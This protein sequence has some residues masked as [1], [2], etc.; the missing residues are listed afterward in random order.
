MSCLIARD[1]V[2]YMF[3][4][5]IIMLSITKQY[6]ILHFG[7]NDVDGEYK[8]V[9]NRFL[10]LI[11]QVYK[12]NKGEVNVPSLDADFIKEYGTYG[13]YPEIMFFLSCFVWIAQQCI[14]VFLGS[15]FFSAVYQSYEKWNPKMPMYM[16]KTKAQFNNECYDILDMFQKQDNFKVIAFAIN[17]NL[18]R[19]SGMFRFMGQA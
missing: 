2:G 4:A 7:V 9:D 16:Y 5:L 10:K 14:F 6:I 18:D 12:S 1:T 11:T 13:F 3:L 8:N 19:V 15:Q 17:K